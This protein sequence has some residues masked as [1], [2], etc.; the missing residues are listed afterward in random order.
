MSLVSQIDRRRAM[1]SNEDLESIDTKQAKEALSLLLSQGKSLWKTHEDDF[2]EFLH[3]LNL[4]HTALEPLT[5]YQE[6]FEL[7]CG[8]RRKPADQR[9]SA[10]IH[11]LGSALKAM[12]G[13]NQVTLENPSTS[14]RRLIASLPD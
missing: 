8:N 9:L 6:R 1:I 12:D 13:P 10:G 7:L 4:S 14:Y 5:D 2:G 11:V 3:W